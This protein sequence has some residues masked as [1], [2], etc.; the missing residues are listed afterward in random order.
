M[1]ASPKNI[2]NKTLRL[3]VGSAAEEPEIEESV[4]P[5][6]GTLEGSEVLDN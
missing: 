5:D 1:L 4:S 3:R 2:H 6:Q